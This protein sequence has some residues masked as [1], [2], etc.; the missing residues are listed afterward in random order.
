MHGRGDRGVIVDL[1]GMDQQPVLEVGETAALA[2]S[3]TA[4]VDRD[5]AAEHEVDVGK[6][7]FGDHPAVPHRALDRGRLA[8]L[9]GGELARVEQPERVCVAQPGDR[10]D[11]CLALLE[12]GSANGGLR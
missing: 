8:D 7:L 11:Q 4:Q 10:H 12:R 3:G 1:P 6:V 9:L 5:R 2:H